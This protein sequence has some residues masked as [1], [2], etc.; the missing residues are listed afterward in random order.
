[1]AARR[2]SKEFSFDLDGRDVPVLLR[3]NR[4]AR[5]IILRIDPK[6]DGVALTASFG[7]ASFPL[8]G[9]NKAELIKAADQAMFRVKDDA[10]NG[11]VV[12][13]EEYDDE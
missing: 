11:I 9:K 3:R 13:G 7:V 8:H 6:T 2:K 1:M 10:K 5:R 12:A 4:Q